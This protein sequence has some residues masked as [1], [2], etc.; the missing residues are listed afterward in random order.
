MASVVV[1]GIAV[2]IAVGGHVALDFCN[3]RA[4]WGSP[5]PKEYLHGHAHLCVWARENGLIPARAVPRLR[6]AATADPDAA[7]RVVDRAI[8]FREALHAVLT[9]SAGRTDWRLLDEEIRRAAA[10]W[11]LVPA[12]TPADTPAHWRLDDT[13]TALSNVELPLLAVARAA[14]DLL[15]SP[16]GAVVAACPGQGCGWLFSDPRRRRRWCSMAWCGNRAK[17]RRHAERH[18]LPVHRG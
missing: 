9:G 3:T 8:A 18:R 7:R 14:V 11:R 6:R 2:P 10:G 12:E 5:R 4:G 15:T 16:A 13:S 17:V 1:D